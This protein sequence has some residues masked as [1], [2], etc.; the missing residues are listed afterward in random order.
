MPVLTIQKGVPD[1]V[2]R[3]AGFPL[4]EDQDPAF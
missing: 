1:R 4:F 3:D 2:F